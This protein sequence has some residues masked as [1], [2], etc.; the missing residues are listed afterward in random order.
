MANSRKI[1]S[2]LDLNVVCVRINA[3]SRCS[4]N[5]FN[6]YAKYIQPWWTL[7]RCIQRRMDRKEELAVTTGEKYH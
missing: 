6:G 4:I 1:Q 3:S 5:T 2:G 7:V